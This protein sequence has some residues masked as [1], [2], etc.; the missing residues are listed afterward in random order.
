MSTKYIRVAS[1]L[2]LE[3]FYGMAAKKMA[4]LIPED[5]RDAE[6]ILVLAGDISARP[7]Q[8]VEFLSTVEGRFKRVVY[9]PGNH[10]YYRNNMT[11]YDEQVPELLSKELKNTSFAIGEVKSAIIDDIQFIFGTLWADGGSSLMDMGAV[12]KGLWDFS[13]IGKGSSHFTVWDMKEINK[14]QYDDIE[15]FLKAADL[16][17]KKVVV[18]HHMPSYSLCHPR[19]GGEINGGFAS[20]CDALMHADYAPDLWVHGHT[21]DTIDRVIGNTRIICNPRGYAKE[22]SDP[23][24]QQYNSYGVAPLFIE[25]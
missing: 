8:L 1:D 21:H 16:D 24:N 14:K 12:G 20:H 2:H 18:S 7:D 3:Q 23:D 9:V 25:V 6:S 22:F 19:F 4:K 10:E 11:T 17:R 15:R 5:D 13:I